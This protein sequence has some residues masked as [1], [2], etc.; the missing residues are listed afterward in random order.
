MLA[1]T[2]RILGSL[3]RPQRAV[4]SV[5]VGFAYGLLTSKIPSPHEIG[6]FWV[7][8][9]AAPWLA[10]AFFAGRSQDLPVRAVFLGAVT[11]I[12]CVVGFYLQFLRPLDPLSLGLAPSAPLPQVVSTAVFGWVSFAAPWFVVALIAG[13]AFGALGWWSGFS[14]SA[15]PAIVL[16][17]AFLLE[18]VGWSVSYGRVPHPYPI[19]I[20]EI[21]LAVGLFA[22]I[23]YARRRAPVRDSIESLAP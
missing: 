6:V 8:N 17:F 13:S 15:V 5:A 21:C 4:L 9:L 19:W 12:A 11:D 18:P 10:L 7:S 3:G 20:G 22:A 1:R 2:P 16:A 23:A 14:R